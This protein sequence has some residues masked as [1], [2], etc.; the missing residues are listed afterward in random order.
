MI[1]FTNVKLGRSSVTFNPRLRAASTTLLETLPAA[2][3]AV[4]NTMGKTEWGMMANGPSP[5]NPPQIPDGVGD[6]T[7]A[8]LAHNIQVITLDGGSVVTPSTASILAEYGTLDGYVLGDPATDQGG[9]EL[10]MLAQI[11]ARKNSSIYGQ[12]LLGTVSPDPKN[13][14][15]VKRGITLFRSAYM[16]CLMPANYPDQIIWDAVA[17]DG[18]IEGG[19]C[20]NVPQYDPQGVTFIT[21]GMLQR[22]TYSWWLKYVDEVHFLVWESTLKLFP[23]STQQTILNMLQAIN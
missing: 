3:Y 4:D 12:K 22:A 6:C 2:P 20:M 21:W 18:G 14:E 8:G 17:N 7:C 10:N 11:L 9:N 19:H 1:D 23:A 5:D 13:L 15:H 16:G